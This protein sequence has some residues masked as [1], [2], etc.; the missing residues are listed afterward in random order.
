MIRQ[1]LAVFIL[2][3]LSGCTTQEQPAIIVSLVADGVE[4]VYQYSE[5]ITVEQFLG[6]VD[7]EIDEDDRINPQPWTQIF[8]G[9]RITIVR[10]EEMTECE[11][12]EIPFETRTQLVEGLLDEQRI[13]QVGQPGLEEVCYRV[14]IE[15]GQRRDR[16]EISREVKVPPQDQIVYVEPSTE[17]EPVPIDGTLAYISNNN[18]WIIRG[19]SRTRRPLTVTA[20]LD[21]RVFSL[22]DDGRQLL[23]ARKD[24]TDD[25]GFGNQLYLI[26]DT[27]LENP[28]LVA[29]PP[30]DVLHARWIPGQSNTLSYSTGEATQVQPGWQAVNDLWLMRIDPETGD[31]INIERVPVSENGGIYGWWGRDYIWSPDGNRVAW[32]HADA[33]G[34]V[35][36]ETGELGDPLIRF[37]EL[38]PQSN[39]SW[40]TTVSWS[41]DGNLIAATSHGEPFGDEP[42]ENSPVFNIAVAA[43]DGTFSTEIR[44]RSGIWSTPR[45]S[46]QITTSDSPFPGGYL[47]Y[48]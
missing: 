44:E 10:V 26:N 9:I 15:D 7:V 48:L 31:Q 39:W 16:V 32:I 12:I 28:E 6:E 41:P 23:I 5:P 17:L 27:T 43:T 29:L 47:A 24:I 34:L 18:A 40:R 11:E 45:F 30:Q 35:D 20:D 13:G 25:D 19:N 42:P 37:A 38:R 8:D 2:I 3:L 22:S 36:L 21:A 1:F 14:V 33:V 46:P 4:R